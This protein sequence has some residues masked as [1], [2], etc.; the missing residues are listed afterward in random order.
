MTDTAA[1]APSA[2]RFMSGARERDS[3][4]FYDQTR[5]MTAANQ[6]MPEIAVPAGDWLRDIMLYIDCTTA[7]NAATVVF[8]ADAPFSAI[9]R[10]DFL[11]ANGTILHQLTGYQLYL[12]NLLNAPTWNSNAT[13]SPY[14]SVTAGVGAGLG[15]SF[16]FSLIIPVEIIPR[17][18]AGTL[19]NGSSNSVTRV[20]LELAA[21]TLVY[22]T[23]PTTLGNVRVRAIERGY[24]QPSQM[25]PAGRP[26]ATMPPGAP[27]TFQQLGAVPYDLATGRNVIPS[28]RKGNVIR[29]LIFVARTAAGVRSDAIL[30]DFTLRIDKVETLQGPYAHA[31]NVT[32][33]RQN[34][35]AASE[36]PTGVFQASFMHEWDGLVGGE[37]RDLY[38]P[39]SPGS[40]FEFDC[41]ATATGRLEVITN[42][43]VT[44]LSGGVLNA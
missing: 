13:K 44:P 40:L 9:N 22:T 10:M 20:R 28:I 38:I 41:I 7:A 4:V 43:I 2:L 25:S 33:Q 21:S 14:Y 3:G 29:S 31:R 34:L 12:V 37:V 17:D 1:P 32:Y 30:S 16:S 19:P 36:L 27:A 26:Y 6:Q 11:D 18:A 42:E 15:G 23:P 35:S 8:A 5:A 39:T 24:V